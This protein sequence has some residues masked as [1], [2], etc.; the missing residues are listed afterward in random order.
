MSVALLKNLYV[1]GA[2]CPHNRMIWDVQQGLLLKTLFVSLM[3]SSV[4]CALISLIHYN[5]E[6]SLLYDEFSVVF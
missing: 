4:Q 5:Q 2:S 1:Y 6:A 3:V